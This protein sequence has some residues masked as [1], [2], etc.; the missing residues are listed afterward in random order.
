MRASL[1]ASAQRIPRTLGRKPKEHVLDGW[2]GERQLRS[3]WARATGMPR[4]LGR[5]HRVSPD[6]R[7]PAP[8]MARLTTPADYTTVSGRSRAWE[9]G[10]R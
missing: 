3:V 8:R 4:E 6:A 9:W 2:D 10:R 7:L 5:P 1:Y